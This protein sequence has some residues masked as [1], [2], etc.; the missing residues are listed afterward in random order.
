MTPT[1]K[2][3]CSLFI[4]HH[5]CLKRLSVQFI[6]PLFLIG[7][8]AALLPV[9]YHLIRRMQAKRVPFGSIMFLTATP[10][11]VVRKRR[12]RDLL[13]MTVR[14]AI[15]ALL[16]LVFARP[17]FPETPLPFV[18]AR[19]DQS[20]VFLVDASY[21]MQYQDLF[22]R[23]RQEVLNR[24]EAGGPDDEFA[25]IAFS[26]VA[27]QLTELTTDRALLRGAVQNALAVSNRPTDYYRPLRMAE[28]VLQGARHANRS[29]VLLSDFQASGWT[30]ALEN[31]K[32]GAGIDFVPVKLSEGEPENAYL[33]AVELRQQRVGGAV[34]VRFDARVAAQGAAAERA[35]T[36]SLAL[37]GQ[38]VERRTVEPPVSGR[39]SFQ[40]QAG[41]EGFA[42]GELTLAEDDLTIDNTFYFT[43]AVQ[44]RPSILSI[45]GVTGGTSRDAFYLGSAFDLGEEGLYTFTSGG[46]ERLSRSG[47]Q[48]HGMVFVS[49]VARLN[50]AQVNA[51]TSYV[52]RGGSLVLSFGPQADVAAYDPVLRELGIGSIDGRNA[53]RDVQD[54]P[55]IIGDVDLRHP[56]FDLFAASG[57]TVI[58]RPTFRRYV[59]IT[60]DASARVV[61]R[62]DTGDPFLIERTLGQGKV[63]VYTS[64]FNTD[65]TDFP[66]QEMYV[67]FVYQL[68]KH[69]LSSGGERRLFTVGDAVPLRGR[70]GAQWEVRA[71]GDRLYR[72]T[73]ND[74]GEGFF[75]ETE[76]PG[77]YIAASGGER[78]YFSINVDPV[79]SNLEARDTEEAYAAVVD[80]TRLRQAAQPGAGL[81]EATGVEQDQKLWKYLLLAVI[82]LFLLETYL[83][84]RPE[85]TARRKAA[86]PIMQMKRKQAA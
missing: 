29:V 19:E 4:T 79:E 55:A 85:A 68:A 21:S 41:R 35:N 37:G 2:F 43:Y 71:P 77:H 34:G 10:K 28:E 16:A 64:T 31:W 58:L 82:A 81:Q 51:L 11:Q 72:V 27:R 14:M 39:I 8:G 40:R 26:D 63:L 42:Q 6:N 59:E 66:L 18:S 30:G 53:I 9:L 36:A 12:L 69:G 52:D 76:T 74:E 70:P 56:V 47:L 25:I 80:P 7:L 45:D 33:E 83:A 62:Y 86:A 20:V 46:P 65:W 22:E 54:V 49:N 60:P 13:L 3:Y 50:Q 75:R 15:F 44:G 1:L 61:G 73:A 24:I 23:A 67:P 84:N 32:L 78:F 48:P 38:V 57:T 17:F 5:S